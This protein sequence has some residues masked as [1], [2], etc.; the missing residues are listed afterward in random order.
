MLAMM[1]GVSFD[2]VLKAQLNAE[3]G[4]VNASALE[5]IEQALKRAGVIFT[6]SG[7]QLQKAKPSPRIPTRT[8][9]SEP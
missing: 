5:G 1:S 6:E 8:E 9:E 7:V 3:I 4:S 2:L